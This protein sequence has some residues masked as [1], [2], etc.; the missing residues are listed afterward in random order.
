ML[1]MSAETVGNTYKGRGISAQ[2]IGNDFRRFTRAGD[3]KQVAV[4]DGHQPR[5]GDELLQNA[6]IN[7]GRLGLE[8]GLAGREH[9]MERIPAS[10]RTRE[11]LKALME[12]RAEAPEGRSEVVRLAAQLIIEEALEGEAADALGRGH[13]TSRWIRA[14]GARSPAAPARRGLGARQCSDVEYVSIAKV[15]MEI[16]KAY[17]DR[18]SQ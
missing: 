16:G 3:E 6:C 17:C 7:Q 12:G 9:P 10:A 15:E 4:L 8:T 13:G 2:K 14:C 1:L 11:R 5:I 18:Y